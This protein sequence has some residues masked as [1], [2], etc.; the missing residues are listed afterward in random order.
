MVVMVA[1]LRAGQAEG[2]VAPIRTA[3]EDLTKIRFG[4]NSPSIALR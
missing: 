1:W 2:L 3:T 4:M